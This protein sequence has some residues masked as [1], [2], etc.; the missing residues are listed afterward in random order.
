MSVLRS[1]RGSWKGSS[2][3]VG[4]GRVGGN[5]EPLHRDGPIGG[6]HT[7]YRHLADRPN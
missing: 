2:S 5:L 7:V 4:R 6:S 3:T 1:H